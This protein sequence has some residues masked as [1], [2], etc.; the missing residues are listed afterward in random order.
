MRQENPSVIRDYD[1][2]KNHHGFVY[3]R[4]GKEGR[5]PLWEMRK[6][7]PDERLSIIENYIRMHGS[8][9]PIKVSFLAE[10]LG[11]SDRTVQSILRLLEEKKAITIT[12]VFNG[13]GKQQGNLYHWTSNVD[14][15]IGGPTMEMLYKRYDSYGFRSFTWDD[16]KM[17]TDPSGNLTSED[18]LQYDQLK[19]E[20]KKLRRK[21]KKAYE[22]HLRRLRAL[23]VHDEEEMTL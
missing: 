16:Y 4:A 11:V 3:V 8:E 5:V 20:K 13:N 6:P 15:I 14:P 18:Y 9:G 21:K 12:P 1:K 22:S 10:K 7:T 23:K 17:K 2:P 19:A